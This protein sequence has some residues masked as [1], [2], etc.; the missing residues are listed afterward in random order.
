[1]HLMPSPG[2]TL[3]SFSLLNGQ[4][5]NSPRRRHVEQFCV[6]ARP[7]LRWR[8]QIS[9]GIVSTFASGRNEVTLSARTLTCEKLQAVDR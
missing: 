6:L 3:A 2:T 8:R 7:C 5:P 9:K 1:M 4:A